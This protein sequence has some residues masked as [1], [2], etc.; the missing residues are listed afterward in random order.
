MRK[1]HKIQDTTQ[2][3]QVDVNLHMLV[4]E[5]GHNLVM[6]H[7]MRALSELLRSNIFFNRNN[8]YL[9]PGVRDKLLGQHVEIGEAVLSGDPNRAE[10]AAADHIRFV[11]GEVEDLQ[12][13]GRR[14]KASMLRV[15]RGDLLAS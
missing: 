3:A 10:A 15:K 12:S 1:A 13:D 11:F 14:R 6:L 5:A 4:Y 7:V 9:R 8:L 2:E